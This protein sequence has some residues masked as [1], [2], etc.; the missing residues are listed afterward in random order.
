MEIKPY[1]IEFLDN[2]IERDLPD[3]PKTIEL[4]VQKAIEERL[5]VSPDKVG[6]PL[7]REL[8]GYRRIRVGKYRVIYQVDNLKRIVTI[9]AIRH[10]EYIYDCH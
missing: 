4:R 2:V 9:V 3:L 1:E 5:T 6:E 10:R 8:K 7:L